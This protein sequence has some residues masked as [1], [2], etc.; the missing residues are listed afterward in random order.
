MKLLD[1]ILRPTSA[2][3][4]VNGHAA[5][6][7]QMGRLETDQLAKLLVNGNFDAAASFIWEM[8]DATRR[9]IPQKTWSFLLSMG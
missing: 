4:F 1:W 9:D 8:D 3:Q 2:Q 5:V 6:L 7:Q